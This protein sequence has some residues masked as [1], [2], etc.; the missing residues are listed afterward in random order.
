MIIS[1]YGYKLYYLNEIKFKTYTLKQAK[2]MKEYFHKFTLFKPIRISPITRIE[3][4]RG[5]WKECPF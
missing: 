5:I 2:A 3:V 1:K 4:R